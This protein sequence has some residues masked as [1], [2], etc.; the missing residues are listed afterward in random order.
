[1]DSSKYDLLDELREALRNL[2]RLERNREVSLSITNLEQ[3]IMWLEK[4]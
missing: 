4:S 1:M 3:A 2:Q